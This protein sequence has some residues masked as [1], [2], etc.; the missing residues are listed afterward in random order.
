M[1]AAVW[2]ALLV[3]LLAGA[4]AAEEENRFKLPFR[5][6]G[7]NTFLYRSFDEGFLAKNPFGNQDKWELYN[8][9]V[10]NLSSGPVLVGLQF[11]IDCFDLREGDQRLEKRYLEYRSRRVDATLGDFFSSF[12]RGTALSVAKT[13]ELYGLENQVDNSI[14]GGRVKYRSGRLQAE[15][16]VGEIC[17]KELD[18]TDSIR[19]ASA[20]YKPAG[21]LRLGGSAVHGEMEA[22]SLDADLLGLRVELLGLGDVADV[23][24][25]YTDLTA[26]APFS[27]GAEQGRAA[28]LEGSLYV[29]DLSLT[30][31]YKDLQNFFF[32]YSTPPLMEEENMELLADYFARY[33]EDLEAFRLRADYTTPPG[34]LLF[35]VIAHFNEKATRHPSYFRY[36][37]DIDHYYFGAEHSFDNGAHFHALWGRRTEDS[38]GY[39]LQFNGPVTHF[40]GELTVPLPARF[41]LETEYRHSQLDGDFVEFSRNKL[42]LSFSR[43]QMFVLTGVWESSD[44]P[45]EVFFAGKENFYYGQLEIKLLKAH[46]LRLFFGE[47][48]GGIKCSGGVCKY[49]PAFR[50]V[51]FEAVLRF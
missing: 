15:A 6:N 2:G 19:G 5:I 48:R 10:L 7:T 42:S 32:K 44:L 23:Y 39:Y 40:A 38:S 46:L 4:A 20:T 33:P 31:E 8:R 35:C 21:W 26:S 41:A 3:M 30:A 16:L 17:D 50:G 34:L 47:T 45:G 37:R 24:Y 12:G 36:N 1:R 11:D 9:L 28:Y 14:D 43:S 13:H 18:T 27:N 29:G 51:R 49:V 22:D 25:E